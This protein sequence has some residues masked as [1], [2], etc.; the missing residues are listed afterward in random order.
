MLIAFLKWKRIHVV[1]LTDTYYHTSLPVRIFLVTSLWGQVGNGCK[2]RHTWPSS[3]CCVLTPRTEPPLPL[4][5][6]LKG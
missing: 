1:R 4:V 3:M 6:Q 2:P 5:L